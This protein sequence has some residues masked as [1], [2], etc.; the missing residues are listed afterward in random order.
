MRPA[1]WLASLTTFCGWLSQASDDSYAVLKVQNRIVGLP[2][3]LVS[4]HRGGEGRRE[5]RRGVSR[6]GKAG[7]WARA[8]GQ[9]AAES[10]KGGGKGVEGAMLCVDRG[11]A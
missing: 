1:R 4:V 8:E 6:D 11:R 10:L 7:V 3:P 9:W 5:A 2:C